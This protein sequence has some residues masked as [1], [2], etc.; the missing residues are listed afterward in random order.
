MSQVKPCVHQIIESYVR[1]NDFDGL[2]GPGCSCQLE[3]LMPCAMADDGSGEAKY[4]SPGKYTPCDCGQGC[5][6]HIGAGKES[7]PLY[8]EILF[9]KKLK[10]GD[11]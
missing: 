10:E 11:A 7:Y 8:D 2:Y 1:E 9:R 4:C 5:R 3:D 6:L